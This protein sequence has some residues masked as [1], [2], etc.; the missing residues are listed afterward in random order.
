MDCRFGIRPAV[1][2]TTLA[3][4]HRAPGPS[5]VN[6]G[7]VKAGPFGSPQQDDLGDRNILVG[8]MTQRSWSRMNLDQDSL[9]P[10][11]LPYPKRHNAFWLERSATDHLKVLICAPSVR[12]HLNWTIFTCCHSLTRVE[13]RNFIS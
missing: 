6:S 13:N 11:I 1:R 7:P 9:D 10:V 8:D 12:G 4:N 5:T 3:K 2:G